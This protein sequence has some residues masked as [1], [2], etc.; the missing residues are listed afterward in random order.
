MATQYTAGLAQGQVLTADI[1]NQIGAAWETYTP[2]LTGTTTNPTLGTGST[3]AGK[4]CQ[5]QKT[6]MGYA[7]FAFGRSGVTNGAGDYRISLPVTALSGG[8]NGIISGYVWLYD[9]SAATGWS[10]IAQVATGTTMSFLKSTGD[11]TI[12]IT[13]TNP[14]TW[15]ANDQIR[16]FF[17]YE[18]A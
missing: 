7:F 8:Q 2:A 1:M 9:Q 3:V 4:Y 5:V 12:N 13:A 10:A 18:A 14:F 16:L 6:I 15:A 17:T 11:A